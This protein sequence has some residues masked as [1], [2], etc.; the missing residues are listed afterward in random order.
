MKTVNIFFLLA[1]LALTGISSGQLF[2]QDNSDVLFYSAYYNT[3]GRNMEYFLNRVA[4][5]DAS[6]DPFNAPLVERTYYVPLE[7]DLAVMPWM[8]RPFASG[9]YEEPLEVEDWMTAPFESGLYEEELVVEDWMREPFES[10]LY[11]EELVVEDWMTHPFTSA[12]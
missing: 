1:G 8:T 4:D 11:E 9:L 6:W 10:G 12:K 5:R 3:S 2:S 7:S